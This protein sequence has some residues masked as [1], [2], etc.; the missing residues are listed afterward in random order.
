MTFINELVLRR[1][2]LYYF[3]ILLHETLISSAYHAGKQIY[4]ASR[5]DIFR[6]LYIISHCHSIFAFLICFHMLTMLSSKTSNSGKS[7]W[8]TLGLSPR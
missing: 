7:K 4:R 8:R 5:S 1:T 6:A 3:K 2:K